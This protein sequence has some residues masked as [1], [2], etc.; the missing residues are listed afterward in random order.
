[1]GRLKMFEGEGGSEAVVLLSSV[2][3]FRRSLVETVM[4]WVWGIVEMEYCEMLFQLKTE[5]SA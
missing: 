1:M 3:V 4:D 5:R 2:T